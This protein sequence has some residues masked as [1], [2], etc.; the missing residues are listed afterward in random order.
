[1]VGA[2]GASPSADGAKGRKTK[3][4]SGGK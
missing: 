3:G 1:V 4:A 2:N